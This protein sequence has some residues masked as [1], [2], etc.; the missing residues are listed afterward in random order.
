MCPSTRSWSG[1]RT[2]TTARIR[3]AWCAVVAEVSL[4]FEVRAGR[5]TVVADIGT[6]VNPDGARNQLEGG[7]VQA[8]SWTTR[9]RVRFDRR[10]LMSDDW[11]TYP[12]LGFGETP[13]TSV[14]LIDS[15][16]PSLGAGEAAQGRTAAAI[17]NAVHRALGVCVRDLP[18][19]RAAVIGAIETQHTPTPQ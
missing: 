10:R 11:E 12:I 7:A 3:A 6:V 19:D 13:A 9:E 4:E 14:D 15:T 17:A 8:T 5:L 16:A 2:P 1:P 18:L